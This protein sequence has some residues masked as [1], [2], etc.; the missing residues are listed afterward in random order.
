V[1]LQQPA[2][3]PAQTHESAKFTHK[4][5]LIACRIDPAGRYVYAGAQDNSVQRWEIDTGKQAALVAHDSWVRAIAFHPK[6]ETVYTGG[7]DGRLNWW[8]VDD[9]PKPTRT[10]EAHKAWI[11]SVATNAEGTLVA[12]ASNDGTVKVW[13]TA[14][15]A[16]VTTFAAHGTQVFHLLFLPDGLSLVSADLKGQI[17]HWELATG[18]VIK[19]FD[20]AALWKFDGGFMADIGG[21]YALALSPDGKELAAGG[22][23]NVSNAFAG[24]GNPMVIRFEFETGKVIQQHVSKAGVQGTAWGAAFHPDGYLIGATGGQG[25]GWLFFW[26]ADAAGEFHATQL[27]NTARDMDLHPDKRRVAVPHHDSALRIYTLAAK[28]G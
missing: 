13:T 10:V 8:P 3:D 18:A 2:T 22:I 23:T 25:G 7:F 12:T 14:D 26:K 19:K 16:L 20:A 6:D 28:A 24:V 27:P 21:V 9:A 15:G 17:I 11:R 4:S 1:S 5:P